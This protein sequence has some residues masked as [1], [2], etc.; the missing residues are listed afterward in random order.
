MKQELVE[1][2]TD[3]P[4]SQVTIQ[5]NYLTMK[6]NFACLLEKELRNYQINFEKNLFFGVHYIFFISNTDSNY[7]FLEFYNKPA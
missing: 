2:H 3:R 4:I 6:L 1:L 5:I 7:C